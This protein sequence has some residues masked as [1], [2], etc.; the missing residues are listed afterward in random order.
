MKLALDFDSTVVPILNVIRR[1]PG[2]ERVSYEDCPTWDS[3]PE[4]CGGLDRMIDLCQTAFSFELMRDELPYDGCAEYLTQKAH[5]GVHI[6]LMTDRPVAFLDHVAR[7]C[8]H[9]GV[10]YSDLTCEPGLDKVAL[11]GRLGIDT[12]VDDKPATM[13]QAHAA[14][15]DVLA[16]HHRYVAPVVAELRLPVTPS[17]HEIGRE[18]DRLLGMRA[19]TRIGAPRRVR[20]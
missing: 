11:M 1:L 2:G 7:Y 17:W 9:F 19:P 13:R 4:L 8:D 6:H 15:F 3:L 16:L 18:L 14:G 10:P 5:D 12:I 20:P